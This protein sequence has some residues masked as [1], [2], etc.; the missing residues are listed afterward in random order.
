MDVLKFVH[1]E[2]KIHNAASAMGQFV[3]EVSL[4]QEEIST[5][6]DKVRL[7]YIDVLDYFGEDASM[8]SQDFFAILS[9]FINEFSNT[10]DAVLRKEK[11]KLKKSSRSLSVKW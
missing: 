8:P 11:N 4:Q 10:T 3:R 5:L 9:K 7:N 1:T 6:F 2:T